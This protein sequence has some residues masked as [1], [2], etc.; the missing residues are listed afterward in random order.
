MSRRPQLLRR[1]KIRNLL[2]LALLLSGIIPLVIS[3][4][5]LIG[6]NRSRLE[7][8]ERTQLTQSA[9]ALSRDVS[10]QVAQ[11][12][13][14]L[15]HVGRGLLVVPG[16]ASVEERLREEWVQRYV[17]EFMLGD[18]NLHALRVLDST[19]TG[20]QIGRADLPESVKSVRE[21]AFK[22]ALAA[23]EPVFRFVVLPPAN[24]PAVSIAVPVAE[25]TGGVALIVEALVRLPLLDA[26]FRR[27]AEG[28]VAIFLIDGDGQV[29]WSEG[30]GEEG[31]RALVEAGLAESFVGGAPLA[32]T[33]EYPGVGGRRM[34]AQ[35]SPVAATGWA[36]VVQKPASAAFA[37]IDRMVVSAVAATGLLLLLAL[38][39]A[40]VAARWVSL[41]IQRLAKTSHEIAEG[42]FGRRMEEGGLP[43]ELADL[44]R[45]FNRMSGHVE[46]YISRLREAARV[47][48][49][50]FIGSIRA[51]A[52][53][54]DAKDPYTRGHSERV[55]T[56][57]RIIARQ[58]SLPEEVQ[59]TI[60]I[61]ALL[62]D[63]GKIGVEDRVL[64][65]V[66]QLTAEE[67][68]QMKAHT[69]VG[70]EIA[71]SIEQLRGMIPAIRWHHE[72]WDGRGYPDG[73]KGEE[74]PL[75]ARIVAVADTF[76]AVT[77]NRPY[78]KAYT[79]E[80]AIDIITKLTGS[81]FDARVVTAFLRAYEAGEIR[82]PDPGPAPRAEA[83][84]VSRIGVGPIS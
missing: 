60:W 13:S 39:V 15:R 24:E 1:P 58:L 53:A 61:G 69:I 5:V 23:G 40:A 80:E 76:D 28:R 26:V 29:L 55:A 57:S 59:Q 22:A 12:H 27:E 2:F 7:T 81:R 9:E 25:E 51:F 45:D 64:R 47:N 72:A 37:A 21:A 16:P 52:A 65:K 46:S 34:L 71:G 20:R 36:V 32:L 41:P 18:S 11:V 43:A 82:T 73:K 10:D 8:E 19:G 50:L 31:R 3:N 35:V 70:A 77:T 67:Y 74:I 6:Q 44:A 17:Q 75:S 49:E 56:M 38:A 33:T 48:R 84:K 4:A 54:I 79:L 66:G 78:Q 14:A 68:E 62:H 42:S 30:V 83:A 63:V